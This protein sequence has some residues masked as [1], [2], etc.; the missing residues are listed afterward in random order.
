MNSS[1]TIEQLLQHCARTM[2][3]HRASQ[4]SEGDCPKIIVIGTHADKVWF[5]KGSNYDKKNAQILQLL[6]PMLEKQIIYYDASTRRVLFPV[7]SKTPASNDWSVIDQVRDVLLGETSIPPADIPARW[8]ALEI[9]LEEMSQALG[10]G[11]LSRQDCFAAAIEKLHFEEDAGEFDAAIH[12]LDEL[13]VLL[14]YPRI[15]PDIVF[16]DPQVVLDKITELVIASFER[17][18]KGHNDSWRKFYE[19]ALVTIEFLSQSDFNKHY[20]PGL[21]DVHDLIKLFKKLLIFAHFSATELLV[22]ALL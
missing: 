13:S 2:H 5:F 19:F 10:R 22:P 8:F 9:L 16:A 18:F 21:F 4:G 1:Q 14:Y 3:S 12:Y 20:V 6:Q 17:K 15:L 11:V 7:N